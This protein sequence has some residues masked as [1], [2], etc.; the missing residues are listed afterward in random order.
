M[1]QHLFYSV[2][3]SNLYLSEKII[4]KYDL[5]YVANKHVTRYTTMRTRDRQPYQRIFIL[6]ELKQ[7]IL[8]FLQGTA[9]LL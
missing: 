4:I 6:E 7:S 3:S 9:K 8:D 5:P 1:L 2:N